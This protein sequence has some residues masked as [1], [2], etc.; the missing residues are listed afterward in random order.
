MFTGD[1]QPREQSIKE[2]IEAVVSKAR[3]EA[4]EVA[5]TVV[6]TP[7]GGEKK[8]ESEESQSSSSNSSSSDSDS[9]GSE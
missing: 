3:E 6:A 7:G 2:S 1:I 4:G 9:S 8:E 5:P